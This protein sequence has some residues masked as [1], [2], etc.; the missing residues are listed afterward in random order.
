MSKLMNL[1]IMATLAFV[2]SSASAEPNA[3]HPEIEL[4]IER[5]FPTEP[6]PNLQPEQRPSPRLD[7]PARMPSAVASKVSV[8]MREDK[9][10]KRPLEVVVGS[11]AI[12]PRRTR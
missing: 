4:A 2:G 1:T 11:R 9:R 5:H 6:R 10:E 12:R 8:A 3:R 7:A